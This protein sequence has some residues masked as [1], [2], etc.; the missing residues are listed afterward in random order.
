VRC[1]QSGVLPVAY[2]DKKL[3]VIFVRFFIAPSYA[4]VTANETYQLPSPL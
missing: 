1:V 3:S 2:R 4:N